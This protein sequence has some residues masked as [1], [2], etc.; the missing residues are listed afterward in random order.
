MSKNSRND[1]R[2]KGSVVQ[3]ADSSRRAVRRNV[4]ASATPGVKP[5]SRQDFLFADV[6]EEVICPICVGRGKVAKGVKD[7]IVKIMRK[8]GRG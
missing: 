8:G 7:D 1:E 3:P 2:S 4:A 5:G 6:E